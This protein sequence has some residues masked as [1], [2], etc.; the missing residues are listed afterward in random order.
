LIIHF[1]FGSKSNLA[2]IDNLLESYFGHR[3]HYL[4]RK[5]IFY[6]VVSLS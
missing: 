1:S 6:F 2:V 4:N 5:R 3:Q